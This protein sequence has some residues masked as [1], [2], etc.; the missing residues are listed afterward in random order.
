MSLKSRLWRQLDA[1]IEAA[2]EPLQRATLRAQR[3]VLM[4]RH[5]REDQARDE[6]S[7]LHMQAFQSP[8]SAL[9][10]WL[11]Y[12]EGL[13]SYFSDMGSNAADK[14]R[15]AEAA[16]QAQGL[17]ELQALAAAWQAY[18]AFVRHDVK[19]LAAHAQG[20]RRLAVPGHHAAL[21]RLA[22][23]LG[24]A[25][26]FA[27]TEYSPAWYAEARRHAS[28]EGDDAS[29]SALIY[30]M[31]AM[32]VARLRRQHLDS[33]T[34]AMPEHLL[35]ADSVAHYDAAVDVAVLPHLTPLLRAQLLVLQ[36]DYAQAQALYAEHLPPAR[37]RGLA[38]LGSS[39]LAEVAWCRVNLGEPELALQQAQDAEQEL[40]L[41]TDADDRAASLSRLAQVYVALGRREQADGLTQRAAAEWSQV[42]REQ[43]EWTG[44]LTAA[45]LLKP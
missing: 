23:V 27:G 43:A 12:A 31:T 9:S 7:A 8:N 22:I 14:L 30:N 37:A 28:A 39:L 13:T 15:R 32:R 26:D 5:G 6:L 29:Q 4:A 10:A 42:K 24:I 36:G 17:A 19:A 35:G 34:Q 3:A 18:M 45:G 38:R 20:A 16:A 33:P 2:P 11:H 21:G 25:H 1:A 44:V 41:A 40:D